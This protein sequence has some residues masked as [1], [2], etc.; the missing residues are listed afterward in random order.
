MLIADL[1]HASAAWDASPAG[2]LLRALPKLLLYPRVRTLAWFRLSQWAWRHRL[3]PLAYL[4]QARSIRGAG[5]E[6]HPAAV[7]GPGLLL[8]HSVGIVVGHQVVAGSDLVLHHGVTLGHGGSTKG[9]PRLGDG[10]RIGAGAVVLGPVHIGNG[11]K[12]GAA[13]VVLG[14]VPAGATVTGLWKG[15][16]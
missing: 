7:I 14:D 2:V 15:A 6:L 3:R 4:C 11:A 1:R 10:V 12:I 5:A 16:D 13:A 8:V 9:Q